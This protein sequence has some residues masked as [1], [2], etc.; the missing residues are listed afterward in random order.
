MRLTVAVALLCLCTLVVLGALLIGALWATSTASVLAL[1][2]GWASLRIMLNEVAQTRREAACDRAVQAQAYRV[3]VSERA[4]DH[5][6]FAASMTER[7]RARE[8]EIH[9]LHGT[10]RL[11]EA[12]AAAASER[13]RTESMRTVQLQARV[14]DLTRELEDERTDAD[15]LASWEGTDAPTVVNLLD[16]EERRQA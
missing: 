4:A 15:S 5:E 2:S 10:I 11:T 7:V 6:S 12:L 9:E 14:D 1:V 8:R 16:W 3:I 13:V